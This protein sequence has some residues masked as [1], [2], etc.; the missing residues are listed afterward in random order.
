MI[1]EPRSGTRPATSSTGPHSQL[2][3]NASPELWGRLNYEVFQLPGVVEGHSQASLVSSRAVLL[4][5]LLDAHV[6]DANLA[7]GAPLEPA[8]LH[9]ATDTSVHLCLPAPRA[10]EVCELGW[11]EP[12]GYAGHDTEIMV[13]G[14]RTAEDLTVILGLIE[15]SIAFARTAAAQ[16]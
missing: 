3:Q 10:A 12:H 7:G 9:G 8:H 4:E 5:G 14:P 16:R 13:Y 1:L 6:P 11:G 2:D 15:E